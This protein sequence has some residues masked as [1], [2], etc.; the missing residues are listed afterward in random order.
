MAA[1][2]HDSVFGQAAYYWWLSLWK[3]KSFTN[4]FMLGL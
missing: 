2:A 3:N 4:P 1:Q